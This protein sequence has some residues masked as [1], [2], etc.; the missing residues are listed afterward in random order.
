M[1]TDVVQ[2]GNGFPEA[3]DL[4]HGVFLSGDK[5][6]K[7]DKED[8]YHDNNDRER[9]AEEDENKVEGVLPTTGAEPG[10]QAMNYMC[11][12]FGNQD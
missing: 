5:N 4:N 10:E 7:S 12:L 8:G 1:Q 6:K 3:P 9:K 2:S 11:Q